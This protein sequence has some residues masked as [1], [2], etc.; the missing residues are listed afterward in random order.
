M[1][2]KPVINFHVKPSFR[3]F[4][5]LYDYGYCIE[6]GTRFN[7]NLIEKAIHQLLDKDLDME[8]KKARYERLFAPGNVSAKI[9][10][11]L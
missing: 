6:L 1:L 8:F 9:L 4:D 7:G 2:N 3:R 11:I 10:D 5:E